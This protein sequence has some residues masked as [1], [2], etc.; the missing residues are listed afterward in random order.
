[1]A[2]SSSLE[3]L[4]DLYKNSRSSASGR[5]RG[6][7]VKGLVSRQDV[8][9]EQQVATENPRLQALEAKY[10]LANRSP[11]EKGNLNTGSL[12]KTPVSLNKKKRWQFGAELVSLIDDQTN[13]DDEDDE[14]V[15]TAKKGHKG[16]R[17]RLYEIRRR[18]FDSIGGRSD[19]IDLIA[20]HGLDDNIGVK[21]KHANLQSVRKQEELNERRRQNPELFDKPKEPKL[22][23]YSIRKFHVYQWRICAIK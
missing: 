19:P 4:R 20:A 1:M 5:R 22:N 17:A 9:S 13:V 10:G 21:K 3:D 8:L 23:R 2:T 7:P 6:K 14:A 12:N 15:D 11:N 18:K 16:V